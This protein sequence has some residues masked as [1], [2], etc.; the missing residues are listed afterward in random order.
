MLE[1]IS[2]IPEELYEC[3]KSY[4]RETVTEVFNSL[5]TK[6]KDV[7]ILGL[8]QS[9][10]VTGIKRNLYNLTIEKLL[11][12]LSNYPTLEQ[13]RSME[14]NNVLTLSDTDKLLMIYEKEPVSGYSYDDEVI[15][16]MKLGRIN[17]KRFSNKVIAEF[18]KKTE[19]EIEDRYNQLING[20]V[21]PKQKIKS[22]Q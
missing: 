12:I 6:E 10:V 15:L 1:R 21:I 8:T 17:G 11:K 5:E 9:K 16:A 19:D 18:L 4:S 7:I 20:E 22:Q 2:T 3:Y 14:A 13:S